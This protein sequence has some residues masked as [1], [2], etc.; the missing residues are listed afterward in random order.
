L[1][2][3]TLVVAALFA[4]AGPV[5]DLM[6]VY[7]R[8]LIWP[9]W[10]DTHDDAT[11]K[12]VVCRTVNWVWGQTLNSELIDWHCSFSLFSLFMLPRITFTLRL[13]IE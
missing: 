11:A 8:P 10:G 13:I 9:S 7:P 4:S 3:T 2:L 6:L 5:F 1:L 12:E